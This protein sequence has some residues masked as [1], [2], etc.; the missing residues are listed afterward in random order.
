MSVCRQSKIVVN[1]IEIIGNIASN[2]K[3]IREG[4]SPDDEKN[5]ALSTK[6]FANF[7]YF[8]VLFPRSCQNSTKPQ[9]FTMHHYS[10]NTQQTHFKGITLHLLARIIAWLPAP[11]EIE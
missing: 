5:S 9:H 11:V 10:A 8:C 1:E 4:K 3:C 2:K 6:F 7:H